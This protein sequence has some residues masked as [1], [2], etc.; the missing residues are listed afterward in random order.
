MQNLGSAFREGEA[1]KMGE[2]FCEI[3]QKIVNIEK[4]KS[5]IIDDFSKNKKEI[6]IEI[7]MWCPRR[8]EHYKIIRDREINQIPLEKKQEFLNLLKEGKTIG[9]AKDKAGFSLEI[10]CEIINRQIENYSILNFE[11]KC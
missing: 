3:C 9:E 7:Q 4:W 10:A 5:E 11:V 2:Y 6:Q 8:T 1:L